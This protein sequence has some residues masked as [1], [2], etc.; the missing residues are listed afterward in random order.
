MWGNYEKAVCGIEIILKGKC[1]REGV[2][3]EEGKI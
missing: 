3:H 1:W 2:I